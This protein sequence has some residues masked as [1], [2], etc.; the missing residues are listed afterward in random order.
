MT[1]PQ[2][3]WKET[4]FATVLFATFTLAAVKCGWTQIKVFG[5]NVDPSVFIREAHEIARTGDLITS[6]DPPSGMFRWHS[7]TR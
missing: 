6:R 2:I 3:D 7:Y 1:H 4:V 5:G